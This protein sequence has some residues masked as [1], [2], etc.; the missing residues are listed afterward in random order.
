MNHQKVL[1]GLEK[2]ANAEGHPLLIEVSRAGADWIIKFSAGNNA[3]VLMK[4]A[5]FG[6][7]PQ[8]VLEP[9]MEEMIKRLE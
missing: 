3:A 7:V 1:D 9:F 2:L 6:A 8:A 4:L 5:T